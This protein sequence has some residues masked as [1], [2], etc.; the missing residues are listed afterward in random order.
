M[1]KFFNTAIPGVSVP[2]FFMER[3]KKAKQIDNKKKKKERY[4]E[5][6][7]D[8]FTDFCREIYKTTKAAGIHIMAVNYVQCTPPLVE[9]VLKA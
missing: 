3:F 1:A 5:I 6:N 2:D 8:Y 4:L 7:I 9:A